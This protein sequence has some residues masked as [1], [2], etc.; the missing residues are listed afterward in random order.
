M[1]KYAVSFSSTAECQLYEW[2]ASG[3]V[4]VLKKIKSLIAELEVHPTT[5]TGKPEQLRGNLQGF[6]SRRITK[7]DR[8]VYKIIN[9]EIC[10]NIFSV[11]GHYSDK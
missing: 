11:K 8:M 6:W 3:Q 4:A 9:N 1:K 7:K 5:G 10:V 2:K